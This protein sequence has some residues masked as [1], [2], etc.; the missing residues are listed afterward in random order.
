MNISHFSPGFTDLTLLH[1][2]PAKSLLRV[3]AFSSLLAIRETAHHPSSSSPRRTKAAPRQT[4]PLYLPPWWQQVRSTKS[5]ICSKGLE[6]RDGP[7]AA[8]GIT[9]LAARGGL[10]ELSLMFF[11]IAPKRIYSFSQSLPGKLR[12]LPS[13]ASYE[14]QWHPP[15]SRDLGRLR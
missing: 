5:G 8:H 10:G 3:I 11:E 7:G 1:P 12:F 4:K 6:I 13:R 14:D 2:C 9:H 15:L